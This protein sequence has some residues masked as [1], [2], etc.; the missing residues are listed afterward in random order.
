[1]WVM[2][3]YKHVS[4]Y[5]WVMC[6]S[7]YVAC[8]LTMLCTC[9]AALSCSTLC[10]EFL[11]LGQLQ[12]CLKEHSFGDGSAHTL[13]EAVSTQMLSCTSDCVACTVYKSTATQ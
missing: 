10:N 8:F 9:V 13:M 3:V 11:V 4:A 5:E 1:M 7:T 12:I 2:Y 6:L